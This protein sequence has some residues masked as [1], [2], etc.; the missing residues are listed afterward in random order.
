MYLLPYNKV[1]NVLEMKNC[2]KIKNNALSDI[3]LMR[4]KKLWFAGVFHV[5]HAFPILVWEGYRKNS[6]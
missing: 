5:V 2:H 3:T 4:G 6:V 1:G